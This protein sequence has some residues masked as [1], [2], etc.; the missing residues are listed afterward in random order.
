MP[1]AL[2]SAIATPVSNLLPF[3]GI[4]LVV[5]D[6]DGTL[7]GTEG[8]VWE[9]FRSI[10]RSALHFRVRFTVATGRTL[11]GA[12]PLIDVLGLSR[13]TP[14]VL[15]NGGA[16]AYPHSGRL[17]QKVSL[18]AECL[19]EILTITAGWPVNVLAY[20]WISDDE[21]FF[22]PSIDLEPG[23]IV[24][25]WSRSGRMPA[26]E[27]N[28]QVV[29]WQR[30]WEAPASVSPCAVLID[31]QYCTGRAKDLLGR[32]ASISGTA[33]TTSGEQF[34]EI[35][36]ERSNKWVGLLSVAEHLRIL[37][38]EVLAVGDSEND[39]EML[40]SAAIGVAVSNAPDTVVSVVDYVCSRDA[41]S[42]AL[43]VLRLVREARRLDPGLRAFR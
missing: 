39:I 36:P 3:A 41:A 5:A 9:N 1:E 24:L 40:T 7:V 8:R 31:L 35:R 11:T 15:Y 20:Y 32:L 22:A 28:G 23:E 34:L 43:E 42:G 14:V 6:L 30:S 21:R 29:S 10:I 25:G 33:I 27:F 16:V 12:K 18:P 38:S 4:R 2:P 26:T 19:Q 17:L 13:R 37:P